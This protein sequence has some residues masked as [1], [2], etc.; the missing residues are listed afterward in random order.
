MIRREFI[1]YLTAGAAGQFVLP[2]ASANAAA[3]LNVV[4]IG[5]GMAG[6][7]AAKYLR[8]WAK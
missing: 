8:V 7:T 3:T 4:I 5:G 2:V 6:A 1:K